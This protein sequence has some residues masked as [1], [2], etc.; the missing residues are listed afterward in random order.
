M[1]RW[2]SAINRL[3][4]RQSVKNIRASSTTTAATKSNSSR[5]GG[6]NQNTFQNIKTTS[7]LG[8]A[9]LSLCAGYAA[10]TLN[11]SSKNTNEPD[12][13]LPSG[14]PRGCCSCDSP[15]IPLKLTQEQQ[16][17]PST[18]AE[19]VGKDNIIS[20]LQENSA[21]TK[22]LKG[23]RLGR[24]K[25]LAIV[26]PESIGDAVKALE[27]AVLADAVVIPQG[28][29]TG[30][31]GGS[32]PRD[33]DR[34]T[35]IM[36]MR[37]LDTMFPIDGGERVVCLA[38][39]GIATLAS[40][41]PSWGFS[42]RESHST[43]GS[44]FLNPTTAAGIAFGSGGTQLRKGPAYTDRA[45]YAKVYEN[46]WG[47]RV[48]EIVNTLG[49]EGIEDSD[50]PNKSGSVVEQLD[51]YA[52]DVKTGYQ[53]P[54]AKSSKS[55]NGM[56]KASD[57]D[58][59]EIVCQCGNDHKGSSVSRFNA[60]TK[61][62]DCNRSEGKVLILA[63]VHDTFPKADTAKSFWIS[64]QDFETAQDFRKEVCLNNPK[65]LPMS[66]EY[67]DR[68]SFDVIDQSGRIMAN[69]IKVVGI[70]SFVGLL[71][72]VKLK[73]AALPFEGADLIPDKLLHLFNNFTPVILPSR[74][75]ESGKKY[76]HHI[77][78]SIGEFG[79]GEMKRCLER[80]STFEE[81]NKGKIVIHECQN[82]GEEMSLTAFRFV[83]APAF[84]TFCVGNNVQGFSVDYAMPKNKSECPPL[85]PIA[86]L[87]RM[88]Y[89]HFGCNVFHEDLAY[90]LG[91][92]VHAVHKELK[93]NVDNC[94][95]K[96]PA[97]HGHGTEYIAPKD[98]QRRWMKMDPL[99]MMN[100]GIGGL[101]PEYKYGNSR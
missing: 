19:I 83:A 99:N 80:M 29:N 2:S 48:V 44:T 20:G 5:G 76:D 77:S 60:D 90:A 36:S 49:I 54:M 96:L 73:I 65:D 42:D 66:V 89:S 101:S 3:A 1:M 31:T 37:K 62:E 67:M 35:I 18:L 61:G 86:P 23:A 40:N 97:E 78:M 28:Q 7:A 21:N 57:R 14:L 85:G 95:G 47:K 52:H 27:A 9:G 15:P 12:R 94:G 69:L 93:V 39:S 34:P 43:L 58:Y 10:G 98:S 92:D 26:Q 4:Y 25:A 33:H 41:L 70:G 74:I 51:I 88:R 71:W 53:R 81:E 91:V 87:K 38:G 82:S 24:G 59:P 72:D 84:R 11:S 63:T 32:V 22:Y 45:L 8:L 50:F 79:Q 46:K 100:P 68:D 30:L 64:F 55:A 13:V 16:D 6:H 75:M 56:A 17:L